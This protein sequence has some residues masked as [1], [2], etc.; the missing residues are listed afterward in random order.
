V[1]KVQIAEELPSVAKQA[2]EKGGTISESPE[3]PSSGAK[4]RVDSAGLMRGLK[5]PPPSG[6][7]FP[8]PVK[9]TIDSIVF[10]ARLKSCPF[11]TRF[12]P[13]AVRAFGLGSFR[14]IAKGAL[15]ALS[16]RGRWGSRQIELGGAKLEQKFFSPADRE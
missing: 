12:S 2:A 5:P 8:Q 3:K 9:T 4:A 11:K 14:V 15:T 7:S 6:L 1:V 16:A 10:A 13:Q